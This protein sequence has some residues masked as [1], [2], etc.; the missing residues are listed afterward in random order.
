MSRRLGVRA[1][2]VRVRVQARAAAAAAGVF[3]VRGDGHLGTR[4]VPLPPRDLT[5]QRP[6]QKVRHFTTLT[7][8]WSLGGAECRSLRPPPQCTHHPGSHLTWC[9]SALNNP[10]GVLRPLCPASLCPHSMITGAPTPTLLCLMFI[11]LF[12]L[13]LE[14]TSRKSLVSLTCMYFSK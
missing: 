1:P 4:T 12:V 8:T 13:I 10:T 14:P 6:Q 11:L 7:H 3:G 9:Q 2:P 5:Q